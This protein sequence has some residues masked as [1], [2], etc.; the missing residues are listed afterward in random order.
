MVSDASSQRE[1]VMGQLSFAV[2]K[3][4]VAVS[5]G[6]NVVPFNT[7][8]HTARARLYPAAQPRLPEAVVVRLPKAPRTDE[9]IGKRRAKSSDSD[10]MRFTSFDFVA[11]AFLILS[12]FSGPALVW[13]LL[14][15]A[16]LG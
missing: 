11:V 5:Y 9:T 8:R 3:P 12:V 13:S 4:A 6:Q 14:R 15:A 2:G 1:S 7:R 16:S 10:E